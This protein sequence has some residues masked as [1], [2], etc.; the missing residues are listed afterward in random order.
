MAAETRAHLRVATSLKHR[1]LDEALSA[2]QLDRRQ[3]YARFLWVN[4][5]ISPIEIALEDAGIQG[6][7]ADWPRR[8]RRQALHADLAD[9]GF[10]CDAVAATPSLPTAA[11]RMGLAYVI[12]GSRLGAAVLSQR[13]RASRD[14]AV[15]RA[16]RFIDHGRA[17]GLWRAFAARLEEVVVTA[18]DRRQAEAAALWGFDQFLQRASALP[19]TA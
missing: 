6:D 11:A 8:A 4:A 13:M 2:L 10:P 12:E 3:D 5:A 16:M 17:E 14:P 18:K 15:P 7:L 1:A 9:L 19:A